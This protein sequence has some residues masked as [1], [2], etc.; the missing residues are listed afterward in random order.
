MPFTISS[1]GKKKTILFALQ[2]NSRRLALSSLLG[3]S[4]VCFPD[5]RHVSFFIEVPLRI[6]S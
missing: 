3:L 5:V 2:L 4:E 1:S 6:T